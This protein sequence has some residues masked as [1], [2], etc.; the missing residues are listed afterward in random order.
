MTADEVEDRLRRALLR[1]AAPSSD[2]DLNPAIHRPAQTL[3][4]AGV[5]IGIWLRADGARVIL[6]QRSSHLKH[7][8][9]QVAFPGG[10][11]DPDD[12]G[13]VAAALR[14]A[15]EE[16]GLSPD[17]VQV[18]GSL[19]PH[20]TVTAFSVTPVVALV[21]GDFIP[22]AEAGEVAEV[23]T[24]PLEHVLDRNRYRIEQ[25][26]WQGAARQYYV[27]PWGPYYIWGATARMLRAL[28]EQVT[29]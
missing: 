29:E 15:H 5:L 25:R 11:V 1:P 20:D 21:R 7:H 14:E 18:L 27:V 12:A 28:A 19:S 13:P 23:F 16:V 9:G 24:V 6:T 8:P 4:Q 10:K 2:F 17:L 22:R 3:R 26:W